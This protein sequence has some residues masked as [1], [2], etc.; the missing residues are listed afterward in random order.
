MFKIGF[1]GFG[2]I[3][4]SLAKIWSKNHNDYVFMAYNYHE[5][6]SVDLLA[7]KKDGVIQVITPNL[8]DIAECNL[9]ILAAPVIANTEYLK[10]IA[11]IIKK[12]TLITD[13]GSVK[14]MIINKAAELGISKNFIGG[15]PMAGSEKTGYG[16]ATTHLFENAYYL[17]TPTPDTDIS[18][19]NMLKSLIA[20][21]HAQCVELSPSRHDEITAAISHL[22]HLVAASLVNT[23]A[24]A[25]GSDEMAAFA[26]GGFKDITRI[27]S[28]SPAMWRDI[29]LANSVAVTD[30]L[31]RFIDKLSEVRDFVASGK[32]DGITEL[33]TESREYRG[34][35]PLRRV[36][37]SALKRIMLYIPDEP[38]SISIISTMLAAKGLS[39]KNIGIAHSREYSDGVL[40]VEFYDEESLIA[41]KKVLSEHNYII[42]D[43]N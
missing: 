23:V 4:G 16:A 29:C 25:D 14:G 13:V 32:G 8:S 9:I 11:H 10:K 12:D 35:L 15:H 33:F 19:L 17:L 26:A 39:L 6:P 42:Y 40:E 30:F 34:S 43:K 21:T 28:S 20:E 2:L 5:K 37:D 3:G 22:P 27:A 36:A 24:E 31:D 41:A 1:I 7:A 38:G 18:R